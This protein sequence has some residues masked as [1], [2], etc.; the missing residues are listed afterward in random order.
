VEEQREEQAAAL[1]TDY[2]RR[3]DAALLRVIERFLLVQEL[4]EP[5]KRRS[6]EPSPSRR[7]ASE[8]TPSES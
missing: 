1:I 4:T 2:F 7:V 5:S 3:V 8:P 6:A